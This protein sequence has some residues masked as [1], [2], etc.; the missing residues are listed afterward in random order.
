VRAG[1][2]V[3]VAHTGAHEH[4]AVSEAEHLHGAREELLRAGGPVAR[5]RPDVIVDT[6][7]GGA[8]AEKAEQT[9]A[10]AARADC[11]RI[12]AISSMDVYQHCVDAGLADFSGVVAFPSQP[13]PLR[14]DAP[15]RNGPYPGGSA[16]HD[17]TAMEAALHDAGTVTVLRPGAIYG[18]GSFVREWFLV[19][20]V[21]RGERRLELPD[22]GA[23]F[24]HRVAVERVAGAVVAALDR[25]PEGFWAC[26]VVGPYDWGF[27]GLAHQVAELL[28]WEWQPVRVEF[29]AS[30]HPWQT[31]HPVLCTTTGSATSSA[32]PTPTRAGHS[33]KPCNGSATIASASRRTDPAR[34]AAPVMWQARCFSRAARRRGDGGLVGASRSAGISTQ[35]E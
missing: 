24:W 31:A 3:A 5:W 25:A 30:D 20:K 1:H 11:Q 16:A 7:P 23:Q 29:T 6:F 35:I 34:A 4:P 26:N 22:G 27:A 21:H 10:C 33:P 13:L 17:N 18:P 19:E 12:I 28:D 14:E 32:S 9:K 8:T 15:L 2:E